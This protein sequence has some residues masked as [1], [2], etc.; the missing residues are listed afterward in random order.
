MHISVRH[1]FITLHPQS[2][3]SINILHM[4][5]LTHTFNINI[6]TEYTHKTT[7]SHPNTA[8]NWERWGPRPVSVSL[9]PHPTTAERTPTLRVTLGSGVPGTGIECWPRLLDKMCQSCLAISYC[10]LTLH[11]P[12]IQSGWNFNESRSIPLLFNFLSLN[13]PPKSQ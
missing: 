12:T 13:F 9:G 1:A 3:I 8:L 10:S 2:Q 6:Y 5:S 7:P 11:L 4:H